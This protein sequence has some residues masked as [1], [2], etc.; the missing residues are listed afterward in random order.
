MV[1]CLYHTRCG[2][3]SHQYLH[4]TMIPVVNVRNRWKCGDPHSEVICAYNQ[5]G[6]TYE[7]LGN[8]GRVKSARDSDELETGPELESAEVLARMTVR[9]IC[10]SSHCSMRCARQRSGNFKILQNCTKGRRAFHTGHNL[11][12]LKGNMLIPGVV[13]A[14]RKSLGPMACESSLGAIFHL[15][16]RNLFWSNVEW[17]IILTRNLFFF[18]KAL[19]LR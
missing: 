2:R 15:L 9:M 5:Y 1:G 16:V 12:S 10:F 6:N 18:L 17:T 13:H 19:P 8:T 4:P 14:A 11:R 3:S 7:M